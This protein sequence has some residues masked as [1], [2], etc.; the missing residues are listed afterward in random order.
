[1]SSDPIALFRA[2]Q[3]EAAAAGV[4]LP[5]A[6]TLATADDAGRPSARTVLLKSVDERGFVFFTDRKS[7][8]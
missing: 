5:E 7:V 4:T 1:M 2:W 3:D 8:V 6:M